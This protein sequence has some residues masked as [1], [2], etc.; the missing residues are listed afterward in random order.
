MSARKPKPPANVVSL[1]DYR[2][3]GVA[4]SP[5]AAPQMMEKIRLVVWLADTYGVDLCV[6][7]AV[8]RGGIPLVA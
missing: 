6:A 5:D 4:A 7:A 2:Q 8:Q 1:A 3:H